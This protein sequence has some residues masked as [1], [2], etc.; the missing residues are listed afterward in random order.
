MYRRTAV[1][2]AAAAAIITAGCSSISANNSIDANKSSETQSVHRSDLAK[3]VYLAAQTLSDRAE[4]LDRSRPIVVSTIVS[5]DKLDT[6]STF[7]RLASQLVANRIQQRGFLVRDVTYMR[8][9]EVKEGTGELVLTRE[10][11]KLSEKI[12]AQAVVAGTYAVAGEEIYLNLRLL[13]SESGE[14]ISSADAVIPLDEN[15]GPMFGY[16]FGRHAMV[17]LDQFEDRHVVAEQDQPELPKPKAK[18]SRSEERKVNLD[19]LDDQI[20]T[21]QREWIP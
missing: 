19:Q 2:L 16:N 17:S 20:R 7:G 15:T 12:K 11:S 6:S 14:I 5:V 9:L 8:M 13:N 10:A 3:L 21:A 4:L 1:L 18:R